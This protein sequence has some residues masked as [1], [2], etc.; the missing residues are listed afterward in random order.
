MPIYNLIEYSANYSE[1]TGSL[2]FYSKDKTS[3]FNNN[4]SLIIVSLVLV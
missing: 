2:W 4:I 1:T 3:D